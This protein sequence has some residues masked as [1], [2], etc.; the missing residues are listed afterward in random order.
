MNALHDGEHLTRSDY[1]GAEVA[2]WDA[3]RV[4]CDLER[5]ADGQLVVPVDQ[6]AFLTRRARELVRACFDLEVSRQ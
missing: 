6:F 3:H 1:V 2:L 4:L 5:I